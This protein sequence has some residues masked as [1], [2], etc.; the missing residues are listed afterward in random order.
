MCP[1]FPVISWGGGGEFRL[2]N[3]QLNKDICSMCITDQKGNETL[4]ILQQ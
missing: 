3:G 4:E 1:E 2:N